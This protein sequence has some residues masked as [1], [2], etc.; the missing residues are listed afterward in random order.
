MVNFRLRK[1]E[2]DLANHEAGVDIHEEEMNEVLMK[3]KVKIL[4][5]LLRFC[6]A[7]TEWC[8]RH[9]NAIC[10]IGFTC[11]PPLKKAGS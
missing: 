3:K 5:N 9:H 2:D 7:T 4:K 10:N 1:D 6:V 8:L 11:Y